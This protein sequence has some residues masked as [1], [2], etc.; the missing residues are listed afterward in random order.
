MRVVNLC[1][2]KTVGWEG[3][4]FVDDDGRIR[5][6][7][8]VCIWAPT[9]HRLDSLEMVAE[10]DVQDILTYMAGRIEWEPIAALLQG[11]LPDFRQD[12]EYLSRSL[13]QNVS[14]EISDK[15]VRI[16]SP[17][18][19]FVDMRLSSRWELEPLLDNYHQVLQMAKAQ[20]VKVSYSAHMKRTL[21]TEWEMYKSSVVEQAAL[22]RHLVTQA[23]VV[24]TRGIHCGHID[25]KELAL[26]MGI[27]DK[28]MPYEYGNSILSRISEI[29]HQL[30]T[31]Q[32]DLTRNPQ[33]Y[34]MI[35]L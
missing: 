2:H 31:F 27:R 32:R 11:E 30:E 16:T 4:V 25:D 34:S 35:V 12:V 9:P 14:Y 10:V 19:C 28:L 33:C 18:T 3:L 26:M 24:E 21:V 15:H 13:I 23:H 22:F 6:T 7:N 20:K 17:S 8:G 5:I 29:A 1:R